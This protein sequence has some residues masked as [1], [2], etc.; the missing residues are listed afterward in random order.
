MI[1]ARVDPTPCA[2]VKY[3]DTRMTF[4][5]VVERASVGIPQTFNLRRVAPL[6]RKPA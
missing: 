5:L 3:A 6:T 4:H 2:S 1:T